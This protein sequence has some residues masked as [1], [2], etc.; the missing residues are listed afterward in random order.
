MSVKV[1][2]LYGVMRLKDAQFKRQLRGA[3][4]RLGGLSKALRIGVAGAAVAAGGA[5]VGMAKSGLDNIREVDKATQ[6]FRAQTGASGD[7]A[8][9]FSDTIRDLH[10]VNTDSYEELAAA[11]TAVRHAHGELGDDAEEIT[12]QYLDFAKVTGIDAPHAIEE[13]SN[14]LD[15]WGKEADEV[16]GVMDMLLA[17]AQETEAEAESLMEGITELAPQFQAMGMGI[18]ESAAML[19]H[20]EDAGYGAREVSRL[21]RRSFD[22]MKDPT[23]SQRESLE[24]LGVEFDEAGQVMGGAEEGMQRIVERLSE[25]EISAD[26]MS[27]VI[28]ILG[29]RMGPD[30]AAALQDGEEGMEELMAT[31][32]DSEGTVQKASDEYD[33]SLGERWQLI[34]RRYLEPFMEVLG[35]HLMGLLERLLGAVERWG[36]TVQRIFDRVVSFVTRLFS[37]MAS[38]SDSTF[39]SMLDSVMGIL[40]ALWEFIQEV[41]GWIQAL[42]DEFG[43]DLIYRAE[44]AWETIWG[45]LDGVLT[46]IKGLLEAFMGLITGDWERFGEGLQTLWEGVWSAISSLVTGARDFLVNVFEGI[47]DRLT[48]IWQGLWE[49]F[50]DLVRGP[51]NT[52]VGLLNGMLAGIEGAINLVIRGINAFIS[53]TNRA[54]RTLNR[55]PGVN[56]PKIN[57][58]SEVEIGRVPKM[59][60][61]GLVEGPGL[62]EVGPGVKEIVRTPDLDRMKGK[63]RDGQKDPAEMNIEVN[64]TYYVDSNERAKTANDDLLRKVRRRGLRRA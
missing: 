56:L 1:G 3:R 34:R 29:R 35:V 12:Q 25:G 44:V 11:A 27:H 47:R 40:G 32:A 60:T 22:R 23:D 55:V 33:K 42:W 15:R 24:A 7:E 58:L 48:A 54:I 16:E 6:N 45:V 9:R 38:D 51:V 61:G 4:S 43:E 14:G 20:F 50:A 36:P 63:A 49:G 2:E 62:F 37:G 31:I 52:V 10:K 39:S 19:G 21:M 59:D 18:E 64:A 17:V 8:E 30:F 57:E 26:D 13:L 5:L 28:E 41:V 53:T 46:G